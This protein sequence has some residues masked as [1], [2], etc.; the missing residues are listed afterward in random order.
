MHDQLGMKSIRSDRGSIS[1][2]IGEL[3]ESAITSALA[4]ICKGFCYGLGGAIAFFS[5]YMAFL[6]FGGLQ[7]LLHIVK[8][9]ASQ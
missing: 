1:Y 7:W 4:Y 5:V 6:Q 8:S 3:I 2:N 9:V